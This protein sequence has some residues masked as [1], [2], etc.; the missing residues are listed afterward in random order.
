MGFEGP[1]YEGVR[2]KL[3][4]LVESLAWRREFI[5]VATRE[6]AASA[7]R[8][9]SAD[10]ELVVLTSFDAV[11]KFGPELEE[12]YYPGFI[13]AWERPFTWGEQLVLGTVAGKVAAFAWVQRGTPEGFPTYY[14]RLL[15]KDARI[16]RVG[17]LPRFRRRGLNSEM[18]R[19]VLELLLG[20]GVERVFAESHKYNV[21]S[22]RTFL[23]S[24]FRVLGMLTVLSIPGEG[25]YVRWS[26]D[27]IEGHL[28]DLEI[29]SR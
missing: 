19:S 1:F 12:Q 20:D 5:F 14:G 29:A 25:E 4:F 9:N 22:V 6:S 27:G 28:R 8:L 11:K 23:K 13:D 15:A 3:R 21:P 2:G 26:A 7:P 18:M 24:G 17:V 10:I 16:L